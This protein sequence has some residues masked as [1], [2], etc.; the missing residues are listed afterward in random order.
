MFKKN[1]RGIS[2]I[3][4]VVIIFV[5]A[6][7]VNSFLRSKTDQ[8]SVQEEEE[9]LAVLSPNGGENLV[10]GNS[11]IIS[12]ESG[13]LEK[14]DI[15][16]WMPTPAPGGWPPDVSVLVEKNVPTESGEYLWLFKQS[17][18]DSLNQAM[19]LY[20]LSNPAFKI[21]IFESGTEMY[22][23]YDA[24]DEK[25]SISSNNAGYVRLLSPNGGEEWMEG[26]TY[27]ITWESSKVDEIALA[28]AVGGKDKGFLGQSALDASTGKYSWTI[29]QDFISGFGVDRSDSVK[30]RIYDAR[31]ALLYDE[32]D[33][34]FSIVAS[35]P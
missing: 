20:G 8:G 2:V 24:S 25:F 32:N 30:I 23:I 6:V 5:L 15:Y 28:V 18:F 13:Q 14:V 27:Y 16:I 35:T 11:Y 26:K 10:V 31:G 34:Y 1:N 3:I 9:E 21:L 7:W 4:V 19:K 33:N 17:D 22:D 12:W 29:P